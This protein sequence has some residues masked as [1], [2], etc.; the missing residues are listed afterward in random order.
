MI[1]PRAVARWNKHVTNRIQGAWA[2]RVPPWAVIHHRGRRSGRGYLTPVVAWPVPDGL[3]VIL[4][5]G[6]RSDWVRNVL[7]QD[8]G[9]VT[10]RGRR[11]ALVGPRVVDAADAPLGRLGRRIARVPGR[12][13]VADLGADEGRGRPRA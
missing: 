11:R 8:G 9:S 6:E 4:F 13:L 7:A 10:F 12:V 2:W 1:V 5:Y 3:V